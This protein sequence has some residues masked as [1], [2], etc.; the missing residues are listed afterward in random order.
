MA[1]AFTLCE[2]YFLWD[3]HMEIGVS[4]AEMGVASFILTGEGRH[5]VQNGSPFPFS[6]S[7]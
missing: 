6:F 7:Y 1:V 5:W 2:V 3:S 4:A